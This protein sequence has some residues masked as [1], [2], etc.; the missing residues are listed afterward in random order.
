[1]AQ[2]WT[3]G[4]S[5]FALFKNGASGVMKGKENIQPFLL[6]LNVPLIHSVALTGVE[7]A[8]IVSVQTGCGDTYL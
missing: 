6:G 2:E 7:L 5:Q 8:E 4:H 1:M 3:L